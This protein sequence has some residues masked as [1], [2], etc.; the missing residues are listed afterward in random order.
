M[1]CKRRVWSGLAI[2]LLTAALIGFC[3][4][5]N[6]YSLPVH[7]HSTDIKEPLPES[8]QTFTTVPPE[9]PRACSCTK[10]VSEKNVS[11]WFDKRFDSNAQPLLTAKDDSLPQ[12]ALSWW[13]ALQQ[14]HRDVKVNEVVAEVFSVLPGTS[15]NSTED[16]SQ[17]RRCAVVGNSGNL[18]G[19]SYGPLIESHNV[20]MRMNKA[21][22]SGFESDVGRKTTHHFM[23]PE[24]AIDLPADVHLVLVPFKPLDLQWIASALS[25]GHITKT[26]MEVKQFV[27]ADKDKVSVISPAFLKYVNDNWTEHHGRYPSTGMLALIFALHTCDEVSV[28]GYGAD[29]NGNWHHYWEENKYASAFRKTGVHNANFETET[30][31]KL[32]EERKIRLYTPE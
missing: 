12:S 13:L 31:R 2:F 5:V 22:T 17:C 1:H 28:F 25:T 23:Y 27:K 7:R 30:L 14:S 6:R 19:S 3:M 24:S 16:S 32:A 10:C 4:Q 9:S 11:A 29:V 21:T 15:Q 18:L 20:V 8:N 26:Y